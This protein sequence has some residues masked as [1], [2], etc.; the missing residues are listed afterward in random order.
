[1]ANLSVRRLDSERVAR[2]LYRCNDVEAT[3][4]YTRVAVCATPC[5]EDGVVFDPETIRIQSIRLDGTP[6]TYTL[7]GPQYSALT[8]GGNA[9]IDRA[10][11]AVL[12]KLGRSAMFIT[13]AARAIIFASW[14]HP[15][16]GGQHA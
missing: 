5:P 4:H 2:G 3:E 13:R 11:A 8:V 12:S 9:G 14:R 10:Q 6:R 16:K 15:E 7:D 1:M